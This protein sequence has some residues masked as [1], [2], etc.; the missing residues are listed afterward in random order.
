[1]IPPN[2]VCGNQGTW[3]TFDPV[4]TNVGNGAFVVNKKLGDKSY[5]DG[6]SKTLAFSEVK[7]YTAKLAN[8]SSPATLGSAVPDTTAAVV[9]NAGTFG[10]TGHTEWVDGKIFETG[11]TATFPPNT[12]VQVQ[13]RLD[14][15]TMLTSY[16]KRKVRLV[17][18]RRMQRLRRAVTM[19]A[20]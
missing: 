8:S 17:P 1:M 6:L 5:T 12:N 9:A 16:L 18:C 11:F 14:R 2:Y 10:T 20:S 3:F 15:I 7:S 4:S 13:R 19:P